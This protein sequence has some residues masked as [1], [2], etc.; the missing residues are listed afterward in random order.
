M[1]RF[2]TLAA[3]V[4]VVLAG[5]AAFW[6]F[7]RGGAGSSVVAAFEGPRYFEQKEDA[8]GIR[9]AFEE[10]LEGSEIVQLTVYEDY[11]IASVAEKKREVSYML[12]A[13][14][15]ARWTDQPL[16]RRRD[17]VEKDEVPWK[18]IDTTIVPRLVEKARKL[19]DDE[20]AE[21]S[22][23]T[24][25]RWRVFYE[26]PRWTVYTKDSDSIELS[27]DGK[28]IKA[29]T[30]AGEPLTQ[31][32]ES[33]A[34]DGAPGAPNDSAPNDSPRVSSFIE[35]P[36]QARKLLEGELGKGLELAELTLY[37]GYARA[38]VR[39]PKKPKN[40]DSYTIR[41]ESVQ[42]PRPERLWPTQKGALAGCVIRF[43]AIDLSIV[44]RL[45]ADA[46]ERLAYE[47]SELTHIIFSNSKCMNKA[48]TWRVY[49]RSERDSGY[50]SY[51]LNGKFLRAYD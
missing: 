35:Q 38:E 11:A 25:K 44:P 10:A 7:V 46:R 20:D 21:I 16:T 4:I 1:G 34:K 42:A 6:V 32:D 40:L 49:V 47:N 8:A 12:R 18:E 50:A 3:L 39:D 41:G 9:P 15:V 22:H 2:L 19:L 51:D 30:A 48:F 13:G 14:D 33:K 23:V 31:G 17:E 28:I 5:A 27:L 43:D 26:E 24:L 36:E 37:E 29:Q 45:A